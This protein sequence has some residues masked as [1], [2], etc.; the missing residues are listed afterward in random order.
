[1]HLGRAP[2]RVTGSM[3]PTKPPHPS[4]LVAAYAWT[5][6]YDYFHDPYQAFYKAGLQQALAEI[7]LRLIDRPLHRYPRV[8]HPLR[9]VRFARQLDPIMRRGLGPAIDR[10]AAAIAGRQTAPSGLF[11]VCSS[12][13]FHSL[14]GRYEFAFA[15]G[16]RAH[17]V[18]D[19]WDDGEVASKSLLAKC[20]VYAK[21]NYRVDRGYP[22]W[23]VPVCNGN[24]LIVPCVSSLR[25]LRN[26]PPQYDVCCIVR[27]WGGRDEEAGV[28]HNLRLLEAV[29]K[30]R[31]TKRLL[32]VLVTGDVDRQEKRLRAQGI[33]TT[34]VPIG[35]RKLWNTSASALTNV[36]RLGM[37]NCIPWRFMDMLGM[38]ACVVFDQA[39]QTMWAPPLVSG[40]HYLDLGITT[41]PD[42]PL[43]PDASYKAIPDRIESFV[44]E[45]DRAYQLRARAAQYF[46]QY[47]CPLA[48]GRQLLAHV[49]RAMPPK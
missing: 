43:A 13:E 45:R 35:L 37:H 38:G 16:Q 48:V 42:L 9:R 20:D 31:C 33:P 14:A 25:A 27:V 22:S 44:R 30:A 6:A 10:L 41:T 32:A 11:N 7:G 46:D 49:T 8:L 19:V 12:T 40:E 3:S 4:A 28:E 23:V 2:E 24:R 1:M 18:V 15:S 17:L 5:A 39:P 36:I 34:R 29:K 47:A 21:S 26:R